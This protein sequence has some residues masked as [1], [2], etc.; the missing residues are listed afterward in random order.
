MYHRMKQ[1]CLNLNLN[2]PYSMIDILK[3][4]YVVKLPDKIKEMMIYCIQKIDES[5]KPD[6]IYKTGLRFSKHILRMCT[7]DTLSC[8]SYYSVN[9]II[10]NRYKRLEL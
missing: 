2:D 7:H 4:E 9:W 10:K 6:F 8:K 1:R 5:G 3:E